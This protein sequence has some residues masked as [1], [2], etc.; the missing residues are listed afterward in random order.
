[1]RNIIRTVYRVTLK[2][3]LKGLKIIRSWLII[4]IRIIV[5]RLFKGE[6]TDK[7]AIKIGYVTRNNNIHFNDSYNK[8]EYQDKVYKRLMEFFREKQ[9]KS[10]IDIG[11]G[12]GFKLIKYFNNFKT[13][14][15]ELP[16][17]LDFLKEKYPDKTWILSD[18]NYIPEETYDMIICIDVIEHL[19]NPD[20]LL[21]YIKKLK[22]KYVALCTPDRDNL[23]YQS[24]LGPSVNIAHIREWNKHEFDNYIG[25]HF[26]IIESEVLENQDHY[27]IAIP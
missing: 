12:S 8:D 27:I 22:P 10:I 25:K 24:R 2:P 21:D 13:I 7:Y 4:L 18:F 20:E 3:L 17:A 19:K 23:V 26:N 14:G 5:Y 1:M 6:K 16:P 15:F 9:L 11:C